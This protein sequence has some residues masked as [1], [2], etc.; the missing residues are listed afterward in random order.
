[1]CSLEGKPTGALCMLSIRGPVAMNT[2]C[3]LSIHSPDDVSC[4]GKYIHKQNPLKR[5]VHCALRT[6][7]TSMYV[8]ILMRPQSYSQSSH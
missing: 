2:A 6:I 5:R 7:L 3:M 1:M 8:S 4:P